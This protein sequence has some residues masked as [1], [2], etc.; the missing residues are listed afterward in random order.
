[1]DPE[2]ADGLNARNAR[3]REA[4]AVL[5]RRFGGRTAPAQRDVVDVLFALT[6]FAMFHALASSGRTPAAICRL[7]Q[8]LCDQT[9]TGDPRQPQ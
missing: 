4:L 3:R 2:L 7:L 8:P 6:G 5:V 9:L 1:M